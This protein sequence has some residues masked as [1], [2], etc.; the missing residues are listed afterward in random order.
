ME[1]GLE[2]TNEGLV[3]GMFLSKLKRSNKQIKEDRAASIV[4][5]VER[6]YRRK[7]EDMSYDLKELYRKR[8]ALLDLSPSDA[9]SLI[10]R[11]FDPNDFVE[12]DMDFGL[13]IREIEIKL[14]IAKKQYNELFK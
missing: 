12:K 14:E 1:N 5:N 9:N 13:K 6:I 4:E 3:T 10:I 2:T 8:D 7:V 11:D